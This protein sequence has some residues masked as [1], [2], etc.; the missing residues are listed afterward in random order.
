[1]ITWIDH[2]LQADV[3]QFIAENKDKNLSELALSFKAPAGFPVQEALLQIELRRRAAAKLPSWDNFHDIIYPS[4]LSLE[5]CSSMVTA[6]YKQSI[7]RGAHL[8]DL[9]GG[10]GVDTYYLSEKFESTDYIEQDQRL[11]EAARH[12]FTVVCANSITCHN[13]T[14]EE[15]L[16]TLDSPVDYFFVDPA[17]RSGSR[18]TYFLEDT[19]PNIVALQTLLL[20]KAKGYL[21]KASPM[22]DIKQGLKSLSHVKAVHV[23]SVENECKEILFNVSN[24]TTGSPKIIA[25]NYNK[26][27][28]ELFEFNYEEEAATNVSLSEPMPFIY[29]PNSAIIKAGAF[30]SVAKYFQL[31][32]LHANT[33]LYTS[34][35]HVANFPGRVFQLIKS[36]DANKKV[37]SETLNK[38]KANLATR[39][40]PM[41]VA[42]L[43]KKWGIKDGGD[44]YLFATTLLDNR[45]AV[46]VCEK[47]PQ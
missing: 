19:F 12:N 21:L 24:D 37:I 46:L 23:V 13:I 2:L 28:W 36:I 14:S 17:R 5:Q 22:L 34:E 33:H 4:K 11:S 42:E 45:K 27:D 32:K 9:T 8:V 40:F 26:G 18:K 15:F 16:K 41:S 30:K 6:C 39:N 29:E 38:G 47:L 3:Q 43:K 25:S 7:I 31:R 10:M 1:M 20:E 44:Q 35:V